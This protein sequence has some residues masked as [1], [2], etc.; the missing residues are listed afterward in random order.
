[1]NH[2]FLPNKISKQIKKHWASKYTEH[3]DNYYQRQYDLCQDLSECSSTTKNTYN[4]L[5]SKVSAILQVFQDYKAIWK[6]LDT[7]LLMTLFHGLRGHNKVFYLE[8]LLPKSSD[9]HIHW[10]VYKVNYC[11]AA[12]S[13]PI[14][15]PL[16]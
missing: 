8:R 3:S 13:F 12:F 14:K 6:Q 16:H 1:M 7:Q 11:A 9:F 10:L 5:F 4:W 15:T 2:S